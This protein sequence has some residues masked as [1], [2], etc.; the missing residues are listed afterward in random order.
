MMQVYICVLMTNRT[1]GGNGRP[2][3]YHM[4]LTCPF[5]EFYSL[6]HLNNPPCPNDLPFKERHKEL[7]KRKLTSL[8]L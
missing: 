3:S 4:S 8:S 7:M 1:A 2:K 6:H 5:P